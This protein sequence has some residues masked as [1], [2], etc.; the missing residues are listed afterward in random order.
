MRARGMDQEESTANSTDTML[1]M[2]GVLAAGFYFLLPE[3]EQPVFREKLAAMLSDDA[4][5]SSAEIGFRQARAGV[6]MDDIMA[7]AK[8]RGELTSD[9]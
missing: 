7:D 9:D 2:V 8:R 4:F 5:W 1:R 3:P 6:S